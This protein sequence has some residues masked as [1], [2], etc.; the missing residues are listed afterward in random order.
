MRG[1]HPLGICPSI[2]ATYYSL[3]INVFECTALCLGLA[4]I[5]CTPRRALWLEVLI[6]A[7]LAV[8][9]VHLAGKE[10]MFFCSGSNKHDGLAAGI[11]VLP[12]RDNAR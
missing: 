5:L 3:I 1:N 12:A 9:I 2:M 4:A 7:F 6:A 11:F 8:L 10:R